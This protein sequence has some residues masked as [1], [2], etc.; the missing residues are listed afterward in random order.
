MKTGNKR[1]SK[2]KRLTKPKKPFQL[3]LAEMMKKHVTLDLLDKMAYEH[4]YK[5]EWKN[6]NDNKRSSWIRKARSEEQNYTTAVQQ[7]CLHNPKFKLGFVKSVLSKRDK[8]LLKKAEGKPEKPPYSGYSLFNKKMLKE[9]KDVPS[10]KKMGEISRLWKELS[11]SER[12][13][14]KQEALNATKQYYKD[15]EEY[16]ASIQEDGGDK[17]LEINGST[18]G[19]S[20]TDELDSDA[21]CD[22]RKKNND[23]CRKMVENLKKEPVTP[24]STKTHSYKG[25]S[26]KS[27]KSV[28]LR[29]CT[30]ILERLVDIKPEKRMI[31]TSRLLRRRSKSNQQRNCNKRTTEHLIEVKTEISQFNSPQMK[32]NTEIKSSFTKKSIKVENC[33]SESDC[34]FDSSDDDFEWSSGSEYKPHSF[35]IKNEIRSSED[36]DTD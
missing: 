20:V 5:Q 16:L 26:E 6:L 24:P 12:Q 17:N 14:Y 25:K 18:S 34:N 2:I 4:K 10:K 27:L 11:E 30:V 13:Q 31:E 3:F 22:S 29:Y 9:L 33:E 23:K 19:K 35:N 15:Y 36:S 7:Q 21:N 8:K 1:V 28:N 32:V